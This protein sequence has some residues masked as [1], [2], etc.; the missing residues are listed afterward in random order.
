MELIAVSFCLSC[1]GIL[2]IP[3]LPVRVK[4]IIACSV[5]MLHGVLC[6]VVSVRSLA[7]GDI[8]YIIPAGFPF[9][10]VPLRIDPLSA[11]FMIVITITLISGAW[12]GLH[13][14]K[15]YNREGAKLGLH[16]SSFLL[17]QAAMSAVCMIQNALAFLIVWEMMTVA[18]FLLV[19]FEHEKKNTIRAGL[20]YFIQSHLCILFLII[21]FIWAGNSAGSLDFADMIRTAKESPG[22]MGPWPFM[23]LFI[24]FL[25]K[26][27]F[28]PFHTWLPWAHPAAPAH[29]SG[30]MSGVIIKLGI[31]GIFRSILLYPGDMTRMGRLILILSVLTALYGV[32]LAIIQHNLKRLLAYHSIEN[33]GIIG[34]GIGIG[35]IG[36]GSGNTVLAMAGYC[37]ALLH[38]LNHS[39]FKSLLFYTA[40]TIY[41]KTHTLSIEELGGLVRVMPHTSILFLVAALAIC[42]LPPFNGF[43]SEFLIYNGLFRGMTDGDFPTSMLFLCSA[44]GLVTVGG[45]AFLCFTKAFGIIF[46]GSPRHHLPENCTEANPGM[47]VPQYIILSLIVAIGLVPT[48]FVALVS[49]PALLFIPESTQIDSVLFNTIDLMKSVSL[50]GCAIVILS[51]VLYLTKRLVTRNRPETRTV[52]WGCGYAGSSPK[53]QYTATSFVRTYTSITSSVLRIFVHS[54]PVKGFFPAQAEFHTESYDRIEETLI[55]HNL[56]RFAK[57][58]NLFGFLQNGHVQLYILYGVFFIITI[59]AF[60]FRGAIFSFFMSFF[61]LR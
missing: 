25:F 54:T 41:Q 40:G 16:W 1:A 61:A 31:F 23:L 38:T 7:S 52:T 29:V 26:A 55:D 60:S 21:G 4:G 44:F 10:P 5:V 8:Q 17:L 35:M 22:L 13:Y 12:Y 53:L 20:N 37:G 33:I 51:S 9:G 18:A 59:L 2:L 30:V 46:L 28:I 58:L 11:F 3:L 56:D 48:P 34:M 27:G 49:Q 32:M 50:G 57:F 19:T 36:S 14:M 45:L 15:A 39:L 6:S 42:G 43:I 24:G 47:L